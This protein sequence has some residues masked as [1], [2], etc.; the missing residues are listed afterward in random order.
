MKNLENNFQVLKYRATVDRFVRIKSGHLNSMLLFP[1]LFLLITKL[2][3][4]I[5]PPQMLKLLHQQY[6]QV[7]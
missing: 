1:C 3:Y 5:A 7:M 2:F 4:H 6:K